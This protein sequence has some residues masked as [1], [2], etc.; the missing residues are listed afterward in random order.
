MNRRFLRFADVLRGAPDAVAVVLG[1][2]DYPEISGEVL[3]YQLQNGVLVV[4]EVDGLPYYSDTCRNN[5]FAFHIHSG[6]ECSG[7]AHDPFS[8]ALTHYNPKNCPHPFHAGD[9]PPLFENKG[10]AFLAFLTDRFSLSE[11]IGKTV[12]I[13]SGVDDFTSQPSGNSGQK[14][15]C[16]VIAGYRKCKV[17]YK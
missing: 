10:Y 17:P 2:E 11:V 6:S 12:I 7:D 15:A 4:A 13:H 16:G 5:V 3:F 1:S 14:L 8:E 9:L